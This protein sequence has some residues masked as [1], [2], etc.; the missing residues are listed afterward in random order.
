ML[1]GSKH[2][3]Q[4]SPFVGAHGPAPLHARGPLAAL[5]PVK[6]LAQAKRR[7]RPVLSDGQRRQF[8]LAMLEDVLRLLTSHPAVAVAAVVSAD[9][10]A[11]AF[12]QHLGAQPIREPPRTRGLNA[13]LALAAQVLVSQ[14]AGGL[15]VLPADVPLAAPADIDAVLAAW[16]EA[17]VVLCPSRSGGTGALALRPPQA[18]PFRFG[19]RSFAA[20]RRAALERGLPVAALSRPGLTLDIDRPE[21]LPP[22]LAA[23]GSR[24]REALRATALAGAV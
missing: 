16:Q 7:L 20:H 12:A 19:P 5:V 3:G 18:I 21:D 6:R 2:L 15:L 9:E 22:V 24:S 4:G 14:G 11:L 23:D 1:N 13:A 10:E 17:P 8:V